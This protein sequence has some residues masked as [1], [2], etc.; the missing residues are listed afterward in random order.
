[1]HSGGKKTPLSVSKDDITCERLTT[2]EGLYGWMNQESRTLLILQVSP[3]EVYEGEHIE[4]AHQIWRPDYA[5]DEG[6]VG[7]MMASQEKVEQLLGKF[8]MTAD[9]HLVLYDAKGNVDA[10]RFAWILKYYGFTNF[11]LLNGGLTYWKAQGFKTTSELPNRPTPKRYVLES[12]IDASILARKDDVMTA[13]SDTNTILV[14]TREGYEYLGQPFISKGKVHHHKKGALRSGSIPGAIHF[15]W[16]RLADLHGDHRIKAE[17]DLRFDL[18]A[19]GIAS[20]K[21]IIL[22]CQSGSRTSHMHFVLT[23]VL[24]YPWVRNYDGSWMEWSYWNQ[25]DSTYPI[26]QLTSLDSVEMQVA[27]LSKKLEAND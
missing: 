17:R 19:K 20:D 6:V 14:D 15:N 2:P 21:Q 27:L 11:C 1:L 18:E 25:R 5:A 4:Q 8:G 10:A 13:L 22:Y 7:G 12:P 16:S 24:K 3:F 26:Q 23:E 9:T